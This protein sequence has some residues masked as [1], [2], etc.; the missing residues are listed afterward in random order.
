M[1]LVLSY[2]LPG[3]YSSIIVVVLCLENVTCIAIVQAHLWAE[4]EVAGK[5]NNVQPITRHVGLGA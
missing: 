4:L 3:I 1:Y 2:K 5:S